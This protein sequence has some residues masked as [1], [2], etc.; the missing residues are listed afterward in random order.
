VASTP[1]HPSVPQ[2]FQNTLDLSDFGTAV[3]AGKALAVIN[4]LWRR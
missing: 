2:R 3:C 1:L 4:K